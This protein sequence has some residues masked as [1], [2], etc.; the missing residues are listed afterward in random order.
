LAGEDEKEQLACI[1]EIMGAPPASLVQ[2]APRANLF[3][4]MGKSGVAAD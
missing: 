2:A 1:M 3:F 4:N